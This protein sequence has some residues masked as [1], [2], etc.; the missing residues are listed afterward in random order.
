MKEQE[1]MQGRY[2]NLMATKAIN[3]GGTIPENVFKDNPELIPLINEKLKAYEKQKKDEKELITNIF[4]HVLN[5]Q[6][7]DS[8][9]DSLLR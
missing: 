2:I 3:N 9:I 4:S 1:Q 5:K 7:M 8:P 6:S